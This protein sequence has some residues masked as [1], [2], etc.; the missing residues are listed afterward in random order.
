MCPFDNT[1]ISLPILMDANQDKSSKELGNE[2]GIG[3]SGES[4]Q[5]SWKVT[6]GKSD[7]GR[8]VDEKNG[9]EQNS[10]KQEREKNERG[11]EVE[12]ENFETDEENT[13][14]E[15]EKRMDSNTFTEE[16]IE[17][18]EKRLANGYDLYV[19]DDYVRW[20]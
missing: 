10:R 1:A 5:G 9:G 4:E 15:D 18:F 17:L 6:G 20:L 19:D 2:E 13:A 11:I 16:Q 14:K 7:K 8:E 3:R 12:S